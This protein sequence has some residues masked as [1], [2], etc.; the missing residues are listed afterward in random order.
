MYCLSSLDALMDFIRSPRSYL[1]PPHPQV[2]T[3]I[4]ILGPPASG[5]TTL[6]QAIAEYYHAQVS[7]ELNLALLSVFDN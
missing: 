1:L 4:C 7:F 2:P 6:A 5:K 3:K